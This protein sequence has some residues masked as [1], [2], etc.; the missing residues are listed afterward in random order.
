M[1]TRSDPIPDLVAAI[2]AALPPRR[3]LP[4]HAPVLGAVEKARL[5]SCIDSGY[6]SSIG[7]EVVAFERSLARLT[8][9]PGVSATVNGTAALHLALRLVGVGPGDEVLMPA[10]TF[11]GSANAVALCGARPRFV[12]VSPETLALDPEA[13]RHHLEETSAWY[14]GALHDRD[15]GRRI[16]AV[17]VVHCLGHIGAMDELAAIARAWGLPLVEDAAEA[18]GSRRDGRH[19]GAWGRTSALSFN[20]NKIL[21]TGRG[22]G[23]H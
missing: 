10:L 13:L 17:L 20:G 6:V 7:P 11:V 18:L 4:L 21:T 15:S 12:D 16:A 9:I 22:G 1:A 19:A 23:I 8:R 14:E 3:P 2:A 5:D